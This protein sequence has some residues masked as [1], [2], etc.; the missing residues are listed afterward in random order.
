MK[1]EERREKIMTL[2]KGSIKPVK[3]GEMSL[4]FDVSRQVIVQD[5]ALLRAEGK[6]IIS[7]PQGYLFLQ[8]SYGKI[9]RVV[10]VKHD[11]KDIEDELKTIVNMGGS[12]IDVTIEHK[13]Y[14]EL[15]GK[16]MI[17]SIYDVEQFVSD[18]N[19]E[20]AA[21]LSQLTGGV[22]IHTIEADTIDIMNR[23]IDA[24]NKKGY[25]I[26]QEV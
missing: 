6:E 8:E 1:G 9:K 22:H 2:L 13:I 19:K 25:L 26:S 17:K 14:G 24:L 5:I 16:L 12:I 21:P 3:G 11:E 4:T 15:T 7:T 20:G 18:I 10:A 23:I